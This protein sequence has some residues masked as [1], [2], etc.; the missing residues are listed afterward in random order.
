MRNGAPRGPRVQDEVAGQLGGFAPDGLGRSRKGGGGLQTSRKVSGW[1]KGW[2]DPGLLVLDASRL[3]AEAN[4]KR[5]RLI[6]PKPQNEA[7]VR[8]PS[9]CPQTLGVLVLDT[10]TILLKPQFWYA[11]SSLAAT[12]VLIPLGLPAFLFLV[13][14]AG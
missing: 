1:G 12:E 7:P 11:F 14:I 6:Q 8:L 13:A 3:A 5:W 2:E 4:C 10:E 9:D